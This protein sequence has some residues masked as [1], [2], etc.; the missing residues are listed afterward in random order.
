M[1][2]DPSPR[3]RD[4]IP[5]SQAIVWIVLSTVLISGSV[6]MSLFYYL[7]LRDQRTRDPQYE[8]SAILQAGGPKETLKAVF[9]AELLDLSVDQ[10]TNLYRFNTQEAQQNLLKC[11]LIAKAELKKIKPSTILVNYTLRQPIAFLG[12]FTN[13][14]ID[15]KGFLFPFKPFFTP[16]KLPE[17]YLGY[18]KEQ[19]QDIWGSYLSGEASELAFT[20]FQLTSKHC[21]SESTYIRKID[22]SKAFAQSYGQRQII[23]IIEELIERQVEGRVLLC[24]FPQI[25]RLSTEHFRQGIANY[26][27]LRPFLKK[28]AL[29]LPLTEDVNLVKGQE[30]I[31]DL[32]IPHLA[33]IQ[34][35][36]S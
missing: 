17:I 33:Y 5:I 2:Q 28:Q 7:H 4:K 18:L 3:F 12:D 8:I 32:R 19:Q 11:P 31:I 16:K 35:G 36:L 22:V 15:E 34:P 10:P 13:T 21:C 26:L 24:T 27:V 30:V 20:L 9:L 6:G 1:N 14:A 23:L 29:N 25:V